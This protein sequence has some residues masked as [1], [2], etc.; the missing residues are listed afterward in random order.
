MEDKKEEKPNSSEKDNE[1]ANEKKA[2]YFELKKIQFFGRNLPIVTQNIN[3][4]CPL[5]AIGNFVLKSI[6]LLQK[7]NIMILRGNVQISTDYSRISTSHLIQHIADALLELN[8][9][10]QVLYFFSYLIFKVQKSGEHS[11]DY[12]KNIND[13][14]SLLPKMQYGLDV[15]V[16]FTG[17]LN[18]FFL[19][20]H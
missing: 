18:H 4:P 2:D 9:Q 12:E 11:F 13:A 7:A 6:F 5:I 1:K 3:G 16:K 19:L 17:Y 10:V 20:I 14:I 8:N 15:N